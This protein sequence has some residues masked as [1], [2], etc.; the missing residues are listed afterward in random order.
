MGDDEQLIIG[1]INGVYGVAG[2]VKVFSYCRPREN[3]F[4]YRPWLI[5]QGS[6]WQSCQLL[7]CRHQGKNLLALLENLSD[8]GLAQ[9]FIGLDIAVKTESLPSLA[10]GEY[11][12]S[13]LIG[14]EVLDLDG[15][16]FGRVADIQETGANDVLFIGGEKPYLIPFVQEE[17][18]QD[19]DLENKRIIVD[20]NPAYI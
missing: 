6:A 19:I 4:S 17:I 15:K 14:M 9:G 8:R 7:A 18:V 3:I 20:W 10:A 16:S 1:K 2:W 11:Y 5:K 13:E 12:W